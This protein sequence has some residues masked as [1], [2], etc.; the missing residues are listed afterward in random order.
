MEARAP[1]YCR[2]WRRRWRPRWRR[3]LCLR[4]RPRWTRPSRLAQ[5]AL[6]PRPPAPPPGHCRACA[7]A[8]RRSR[9]PRL[10]CSPRSHARSPRSRPAR[11]AC[12]AKVRTPTDLC[13]CTRRGS[14]VMDRRCHGSPQHHVADS[15]SLPSSTFAMG[16]THG[17][18]KS[19]KR[20]RRE[21]PSRRSSGRLTRRSTRPASAT[22]RT[23]D[24]A[25]SRK[26][27]LLARVAGSSWAGQ[28]HGRRRGGDEGGEAQG[29]ARFSRRACAPMRCGAGRLLARSR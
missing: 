8:R 21:S 10:L 5:R 24:S 23:S 20:E 11:R 19:K 29:G 14:L 26:L 9:S 22:S 13:V 12:D 6:P 7:L 25:R 2:R 3:Q 28:D 15:F 16:G 27:R 1:P 17:R 4:R 18:E